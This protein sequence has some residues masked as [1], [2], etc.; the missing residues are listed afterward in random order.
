[1]GS[2]EA[3]LSESGIQEGE[4]EMQTYSDLLIERLKER[5]KWPV[6]GGSTS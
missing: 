2:V 1:M 5:G 3:G 4:R 6:E